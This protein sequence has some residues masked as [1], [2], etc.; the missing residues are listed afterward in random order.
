MRD[1]A[2]RKLR[3]RFRVL[4]AKLWIR[5]TAAHWRLAFTRLGLLLGRRHALRLRAYGLFFESES[6][7]SISFTRD[8]NAANC[9]SRSASL[10]SS[11][12]AR[13]R[14]S[15]SCFFDANSDL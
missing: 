4:L 3:V 6:L 9:E 14:H 2:R 13:S 7:C 12:A 1:D 5:V 15:Q 11:S 10:V 8:I